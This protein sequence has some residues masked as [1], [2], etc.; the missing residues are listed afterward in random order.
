MLNNSEMLWE[1]TEDRPFEEMFAD[2]GR[3]ASEATPLPAWGTPSVRKPLLTAKEERILA[4]RIEQG[5]EEARHQLIEANYGLVFSMA[6]RYRQGGVPLEDLIQEG[7]IGLIRGVDKFDPREGCRFSTYATNWIR[8]QMFEAIRKFRSLAHVPERVHRA[9]GKLRRTAD[10]LEQKSK[11]PPTLE[12]LARHTGG[13]PEKVAEL[14]QIPDAW[15]S[16]ETPVSEDTLM[17]DLVEDEET[18]SV[19]EQALNRVLAERIQARLGE[20]SERERTVIQL[21]YGLGDGR[22]QT[23]AEIGRHF[24][25]SRQ[26]IRTIEQKALQKLRHWN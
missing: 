21:R 17:K 10:A 8:A 16:L 4:R 11:H 18:A 5:D 1:E 14:M 2:A 3:E 6:Q 25:V 9:A 7:M 20:L 13:T 19:E 23:L 15:V 12:E 26:H 22:E 24:Q